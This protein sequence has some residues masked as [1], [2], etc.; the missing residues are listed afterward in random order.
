MAILFSTGGEASVHF[1]GNYSYSTDVWA[2]KFTGEVCNDMPFTLE[3]N[4]KKLAMPVSK[5]LGLNILIRSSFKDCRFHSLLLR[6][7][8]KSHPFSPL[9][10]R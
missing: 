3:K 5:D 10:M 1:A 9:W 2:T 7:K 8:R 4:L 6:N